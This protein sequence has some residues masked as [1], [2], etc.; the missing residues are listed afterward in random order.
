MLKIYIARHG[1]DEDNKNGILNGHRDTPLTELGVNQAHALALHIKSLGLSFEKIYSSPLSRAYTTAEI[2]AD[3]LGIS[4]PEKFAGLIER[5]I[6]VMAGTPIKDIEKTC[7]PDIIKTEIITY[8][9]TAEG[10]ETFP[11]TFSRAQKTLEEITTKHSDGN[12]LI[13]CHGDIG[14]MLY[15]AYYH[16]DWETILKMFHFGNSELLLL[17]EDSSAEDTHVFKAEQYNH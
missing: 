1:Q 6:G 13:V 5:D 10:A 14:K 7:A 4:K 15:A 9:L 12:I 16:L 2:V 3:T 17:S 11:E 8:F